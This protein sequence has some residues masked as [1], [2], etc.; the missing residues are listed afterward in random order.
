M[1]Q[2]AIEILVDDV[3]INKH[4]KNN[5]EKFRRINCHKWKEGREG[6]NRQSESRRG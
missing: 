1:E 3:N 6:K 2:M 5:E 4:Q